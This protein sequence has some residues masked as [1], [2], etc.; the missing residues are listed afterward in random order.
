MR[1]RKGIK[2]QHLT[3]KLLRVTEFLGG[4][5]SWN[6]GIISPD[7]WLSA[8]RKGGSATPKYPK[9]GLMILKCKV[10]SLFYAVSNPYL[11]LYFTAFLG[12]YLKQHPT[13]GWQPRVGC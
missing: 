6:T 4:S 1:K 8:K 11:L 2:A 3:M 5:P 10:V 13:L 9:K 7:T 12:T